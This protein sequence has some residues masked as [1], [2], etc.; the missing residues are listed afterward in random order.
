MQPMRAGEA[1]DRTSLS[2]QPKYLRPCDAA[3]YLSVA[4]KTL[5]QWRWKGGGPPFM[6][7]GR[8]IIYAI[9]DLDAWFDAHKQSNT[10][11]AAP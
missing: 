4:E 1:R 2:V 10:S 7:R 9:T 11:E 6:R 8:T 5:A 3:K